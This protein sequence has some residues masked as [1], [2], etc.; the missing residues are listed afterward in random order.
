[1]VTYKTQI[2]FGHFEAICQVEQIHGYQTGSYLM[3]EKK[4]KERERD[5]TM[6]VEKQD[7]MNR[8]S[9]LETELFY[10]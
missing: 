1:M 5:G 4:K 2:Q 3:N 10:I 7:I 9:T 8:H 6:L